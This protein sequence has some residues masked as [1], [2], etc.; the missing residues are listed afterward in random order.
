MKVRRHSF[1]RAGEEPL[2]DYPLVT[3]ELT[4]RIFGPR[5]GRANISLFLTSN[6]IRDHVTRLYCLSKYVIMLSNAFVSTLSLY[7]VSAPRRALVR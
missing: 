1:S 7:R 5:K 3:H 2:I 4:K 6:K